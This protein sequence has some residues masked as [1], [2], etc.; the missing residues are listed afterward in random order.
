MLELIIIENNFMK[1]NINILGQHQF[2]DAR[3]IG[4]ISDTHVPEA[5]DSIWPEISNVFDE[6]QLILH[7]GD[8]HNLSVL[9]ELEEIAPVIACRGNGDDGSS[10]RPLMPNHPRVSQNQI[11]T[12]QDITIGLTHSFI[13]DE[14][15]GIKIDDQMINKF[16]RIVDVVVAGDTHVPIIKTIYNNTTIINSGSALLP[17]NFNTQ[18]GTIGFIKIK[19]NKEI[20]LWI[21]MLHE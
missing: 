20:D 15:L 14:R 13:H 1:K 3:L 2:N 8:M 5:R 7:A 12:I 11:I 9:K 4:L 10:G 21:E 6:V 19:D 17:Y 16:G 18:L